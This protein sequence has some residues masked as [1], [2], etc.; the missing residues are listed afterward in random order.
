[1]AGLA[2]FAV[3]GCGSTPAAS[4]VCNAN[5]GEN[6]Q[7]AGTRPSPIATEP[8][9]RQAQAEIADALGLTAKVGSDTW[10]DHQY[11]CVYRYPHASFAVSVKEL[12]SCS[13]TLAFYHQL[14][15]RMGVARTLAN[16]GQAAYQTTDGSVVVRKDWKVLLVDDTGLPPQ[17]GVPPTSAGDVAVTIADVVLGCWSGD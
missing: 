10:A 4:A 11:S 8:C 5:A 3:S 9:R 15:R 7:P 16:L 17:F 1:M 6:P 13:Q 2:G 14:G 12:S